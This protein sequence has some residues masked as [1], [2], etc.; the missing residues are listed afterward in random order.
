VNIFARDIT[1]NL[2][3]LVKQVDEQVAQNKDKNMQAFV[4]ILTEDPTPWLRSWK[5]WPKR[6]GI[7]IPLT[8][9]DGA[10]GPPSY[11]IAKDADVTVLMWKGL[12]VKANH[13]FKPGELDAEKAKAV[14]RTLRRFSTSR[15]TSIVAKRTRPVPFVRERSGPFFR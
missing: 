7:K 14:P 5:R 4:V 13:A 8:I 12:E 11:K 2:T 10:A 6:K 9:F 15:G 3:S 1:D